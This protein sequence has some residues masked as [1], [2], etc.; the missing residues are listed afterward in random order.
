MR[1]LERAVL[2]VACLAG[3]T[4]RSQGTPPEPSSAS[5]AAAASTAGSVSRAP[6]REEPSV[7]VGTLLTPE[8][9]RA[10]AALRP[11]GLDGARV[12]IARAYR[13]PPITVLDGRTRPRV[14]V[15]VDLDVPCST[16]DPD[17]LEVVDVATGKSGPPADSHRITDDGSFADW[18]DPVFK[19]PHRIHA[20]FTYAVDDVPRE[21]GLRYGTRDLAGR[22]AVVEAGPIAPEPTQSVVAYTIEP[23]TRAQRLIVHIEAKS[24]PRGRTFS[25]VVMSQPPAEF[26]N[27]TRRWIEVDDRLRPLDV[28][29]DK[30]PY[31][32]PVRHLILQFVVPKGAKPLRLVEFGTLSGAPSLALPPETKAK[33]LAEPS[34]CPRCADE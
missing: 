25:T 7:P 33:L 14:A 6:C 9:M 29:V 17:D 30:R 19:D 24:W 21:L 1:L 3:C 32:V 5:D 12:S 4:R 16:F 23:G 20:L 8:L 28:P 22:A 15:D 13:Y 11:N 2:L 34:D 27:G 31:Y 18:N 10:R 26:R